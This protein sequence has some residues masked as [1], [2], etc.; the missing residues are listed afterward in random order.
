MSGYPAPGKPWNIPLLLQWWQ[1][2]I[3]VINL[4]LTLVVV[5]VI[6]SIGVQAKAGAGVYVKAMDLSPAR[7]ASVM[8]RTYG[9][10][11]NVYNVTSNIVPLSEATLRAGNSTVKTNTTFAQAAFEAM[12]GIAKADW[13][14]LMGNASLA[15]GSVAHINYTTITDFVAQAKDAEFQR[16]VKE[17]VSHAL[18]SFDFATTG[19]AQLFETMKEG[20]LANKMIE[21]INKRSPGYQ[22]EL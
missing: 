10:V 20:I 16:S 4:L 2:V 19:A 12:A 18:G 13:T 1:T 8:H 5:I 17:Q 9:I 15:L 3:A 7:A 6:L 11:D 22:P 14:S 21:G